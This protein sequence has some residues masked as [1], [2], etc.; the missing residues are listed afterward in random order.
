M[1]KER[2]IQ[3]F[4]KC[5][6][7]NGVYVSVITLLF[8]L[9]QIHKDW[10]RDH[11][12][13]APCGIEMKIKGILKS[14]FWISQHQGTLSILCSRIQG[15]KLSLLNEVDQWLLL[16]LCVLYEMQNQIFQQYIYI[17][18]YMSKMS[19][20]DHKSWTNNFDYICCQNFSL[21]PSSFLV[22]YLFILITL[23]RFT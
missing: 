6:D 13:W 8:S 4:H 18:I 9:E 2:N 11:S 7:G 23:C 5:E 20:W 17:Y 19:V 10:L 3:N 1:Y 15:Y 21:K 14:L 12:S 16:L 22:I